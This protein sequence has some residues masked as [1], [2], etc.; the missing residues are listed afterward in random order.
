MIARKFLAALGM[1]T[2]CVAAAPA[3]PGV[4]RPPQFIVMAFD[5][6]TE[7]ERWQELTDFAA[8]MNRE[9]ERLHFTFF[10]SG[11]NFIADASRKI[12][13]GPQQPRGVSRI[14]FGG[15]ADEVR[16]RVDYVNALHGDGHE[17][18]SHAVGHFNGGAW[19]A[20]DWHQEFRS[21]HDILSNV[22]PNNGLT[23]AVKVAFPLAG[24]VG[25]R[26]PYLARSA[27]LYPVL[28]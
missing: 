22:G 10:L 24:V 5:N 9:G 28:Q 27:A 17:I 18:A 20:N 1:L 4:D 7:L 6:C 2:A 25:F 11:I 8:E 13:Q 21:F 16:R 12:Y 26:A 23:D 14:N 15:S 3:Q 19:S